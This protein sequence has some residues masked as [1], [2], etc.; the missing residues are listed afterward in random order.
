MSVQKTFI[1]IFLCTTNNIS[2]GGQGCGGQGCGGQQGG[3]KITT[4]F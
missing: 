2:C 1:F 4:A 3:Q